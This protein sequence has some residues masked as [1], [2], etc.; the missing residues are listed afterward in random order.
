[1]VP[2]IGSSQGNL[3]GLPGDFRQAFAG[4]FYYPGL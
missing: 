3:N 4:A 2:F 1:M